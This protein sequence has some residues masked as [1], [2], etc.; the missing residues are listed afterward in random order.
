MLYI[1]VL[2]HSG[3]KPPKSPLLSRCLLNITRGNECTKRYLVYMSYT[4]IDDGES[5]GG[6]RFDTYIR[7]EIQN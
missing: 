2:Y 3:Q 1:H 4:Q 6:L 5:D 7:Q